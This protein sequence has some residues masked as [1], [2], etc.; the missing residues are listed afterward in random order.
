MSIRYITTG[1]EKIARSLLGEGRH[2]LSI[3]KRAMAFQNLKQL[4]RL[5]R[6]DDGTIIK[7]ISCF[8]Q[9]VVNVYAPPGFPVEKERKIVREFFC[10]CNCCFAEGVITKVIDDYDN[11][12]NYTKD[13]GDPIYFRGEYS[14]FYYPTCCTD[15]AWGKIRR[16]EGI[17]YKV[18]VCMGDKPKKEFI[19]TASDFIKYEEKDKVLLLYLIDYAKR[20][21]GS[22]ESIC[23]KECPPAEDGKLIG[24]GACEGIRRPDRENDKNAE[25]A[26]GV[27]LTDSVDGTYMIMPFKFPRLPN[28]VEESME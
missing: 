10:W 26:F 11:I 23:L 28:R 15:S 25:A 21:T 27:T 9:D 16:Y 20:S 1:D 19:C 6:F 7:C 14:K 2:Q 24:E 12:G 5:V 4:Q 17:R 8:G 13:N 18:Q 22:C 3:L